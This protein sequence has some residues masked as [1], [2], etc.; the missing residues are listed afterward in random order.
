MPFF[1]GFWKPNLR[2][3]AKTLSQAQFG[4]PILVSMSLKSINPATDEL[5]REYP[6]PGDKEL[7]MILAEAS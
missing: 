7:A 6:E 4:R 5:V 2:A 3:G 1:E